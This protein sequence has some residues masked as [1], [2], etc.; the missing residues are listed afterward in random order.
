MPES[1]H[2]RY[3]PALERWQSVEQPAEASA[4]VLPV[5]IASL[6]LKN[7]SLLHH[8]GLVNFYRQK[9]VWRTLCVQPRTIV[10]GIRSIRKVHDL[11]V[12]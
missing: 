6:D 3:D 12:L 1:R 5:A 9:F 10:P 2:N 7:V 8:L 11:D 4:E